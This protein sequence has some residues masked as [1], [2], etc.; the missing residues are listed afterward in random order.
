MNTKM[1]R[2]ISG[3]VKFEI[4]EDSQGVKLYNVLQMTENGEWRLILSTNRIRRAIIRKHNAQIC[5][6]N[7][8]GYT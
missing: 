7:R 5:A 6:I 4:T 1:L 8:L 3:K 2:K